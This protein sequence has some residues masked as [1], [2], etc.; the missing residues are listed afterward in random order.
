MCLHCALCSIP[1]NLICKMTT[2]RK[3]CFDIC[4]CPG[5]EGVCNRT[6]ICN[7]SFLAHP[8]GGGGVLCAKYISYH[9]ASLWFHLIRYATW[10]CSEKVN[11]YL[12]T[13][14]PG[15]WG[16]GGMQIKYLLPCCCMRQSLSFDM[17]LDH[18]LI[19]LLPF[20]ACVIP[21]IWYATWPYS[22]IVEF[23]PLPYPYVYPG[24]QTSP[25]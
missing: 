13:P 6:L 18:I 12:L 8:Q 5:V 21:L 2:F 15:P 22:E 3:K 10:P 11:F 20:A 25:T 7:K 23:W 4:P 14:L 19:K 1:F 17:Q 9:V 16:G 24:D